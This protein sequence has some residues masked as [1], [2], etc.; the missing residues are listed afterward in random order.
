MG[1]EVFS[2]THLRIV[3]ADAVTN[4]VFYCMDGKSLLSVCVQNNVNLEI[5]LSFFMKKITL[6]SSLIFYSQ[7]MKND[8]KIAY[9]L[10]SNFKMGKKTIYYTHEQIAETT[11]MNRVSATKILNDFEKKGLIELNYKYIH[12]LKEKELED[13]FGLISFFDF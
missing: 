5:L 9:Y 2:E 11:G 4:I 12:I 1:E 7:F 3:N 10:Y 8:R 13:I 6:L